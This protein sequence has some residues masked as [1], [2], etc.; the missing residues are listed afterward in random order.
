MMEDRI[1]QPR[2]KKNTGSGL[3]MAAIGV[4]LLIPLFFTFLYSLF[5]EWMEVMPQ[6]FTL[7]AYAEL[8]SDGAFWLAIGRT[9]VISILPIVLCTMAVLLAMYVV[10]VYC[11]GLD[12]YMKPLCTM[13]YA[14]QGVILPISVLALY[15]DAPEPF[16]SRFFMLT[17][18]YCIVV[19][20]YIYQGIRN[21]LDG[22]NAACLIEAAQML[23]AGPFY[24]FF[25][26]VV[27]NILNG[28]LVSAML[29]MAIVFGDFVIINT[30][31]GNYFPTAQMYLYEV[32][33]QSSQRTCAIIIVLFFVTLLI[34][35]FVFLRGDGRAARN[36][37]V[38]NGKMQI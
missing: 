28:V 2:A 23:G 25:H 12:R 33:K 35:G 22:V 31:A 13:P 7:R 21:N 24:A 15:A 3:I 4:Y 26:V 1:K 5:S 10:V 30:L 29:A 8:F 19:L 16:C 17:S 36:A 6:G 34:S 32:M 9:L 20:P 27:P 37:D 14:I 38:K 18:T 11:P